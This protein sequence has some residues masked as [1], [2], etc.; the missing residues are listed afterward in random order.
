MDASADGKQPPSSSKGCIASTKAFT[1][2]AA[3]LALFALFMGRLR[4]MSPARGLQA[5]RATRR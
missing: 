3:V 2:Q 1:S 4:S 5:V